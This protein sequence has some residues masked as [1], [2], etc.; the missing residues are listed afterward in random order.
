MKCIFFFFWGGGG[1]THAKRM[2]IGLI[3]SQ[4]SAITIVIICEYYLPQFFF[5]LA[6]EL[7]YLDG[8]HTVFGEVT[9]GFDVL[10]KINEAFCD[11]ENRPYQDIR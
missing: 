3:L 2:L 4:D 8:Q 11:K 6:E 9:E 7:D 5:T 10:D 1:I